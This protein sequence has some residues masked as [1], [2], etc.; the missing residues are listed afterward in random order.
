MKKLE[1]KI[2]KEM[3][4]DCR[5]HGIKIIYRSPHSV[6]SDRIVFTPIEIK[7]DKHVRIM[8]DRIDSTPQLKAAKLYIS[9]EPRTELGG[10]DVQQTILEGGGGEELQSLHADGHPTLTPCTIVG[11]YT[12]PCHE[13]PTPMDVYGSSYEQECIQSLGGEDKG[14]VDYGRDEYEEMIGRDDFHEYVDHYEN[15]D[16]IHNDVVDDH[17]DDATEFHDDIGDHIGVQNVTNAIPTYEVHALSFHAN[18]W[19]NIVDPSNV[20]IPFASSWVWGINFSKGFA[21]T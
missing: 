19:D 17:D 16:N 3:D 18:T 9:V 14:D 1:K 2:M 7:G 15:V 4:L 5:S 13:T 10:E 12:L 8:F 11:G 6:F 20:E 21:A